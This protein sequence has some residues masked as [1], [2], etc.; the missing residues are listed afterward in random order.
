MRAQFARKLLKMI[1]LDTTSS[2]ARSEINKKLCHAELLK[3]RGLCIWM[4]Y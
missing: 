2:I 4:Q 3:T 1:T